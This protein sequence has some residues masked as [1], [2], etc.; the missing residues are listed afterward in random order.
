MMAIHGVNKASRAGHSHC[1]RLGR[2][3]LELVTKEEEAVYSGAGD[4]TGKPLLSNRRLGGFRDGRDAGS[5]G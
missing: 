2:L 4:E 1:Q 5:K 3:T